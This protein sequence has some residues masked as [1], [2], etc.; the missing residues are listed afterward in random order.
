MSSR[1]CPHSPTYILVVLGPR[2][3]WDPDIVVALDGNVIDI[4][5]EDELED[6]FVAQVLYVCLAMYAPIRDNML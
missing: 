3:D 4:N 6:D 1:P 5:R 2:L